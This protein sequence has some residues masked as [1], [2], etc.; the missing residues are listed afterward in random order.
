MAWKATRPP[1]ASHLLPVGYYHVFDL[2]L[3]LPLP[4]TFSF[5]MQQLCSNRSI[6]ET[7]RLETVRWQEEMGN[8]TRAT[9]P[10]S[11]RK[12]AADDASPPRWSPCFQWVGE[13]QTCRAQ[14]RAVIWTS[15]SYPPWYRMVKWWRFIWGPRPGLCSTRTAS[16]RSS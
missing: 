3:V 16:S 8:A 12:L 4:G 14:A 11:L 9:R 1:T 15:S 2:K 10:T 13:F 5:F 6:L 7:H